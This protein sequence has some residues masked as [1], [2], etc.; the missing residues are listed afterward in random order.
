MVNFILG[1]LMQ[2]LTYHIQFPWVTFRRQQLRF[3]KRM[4]FDKHQTGTKHPALIYCDSYNW[5]NR[6]IFITQKSFAYFTSIFLELNQLSFGRLFFV[7]IL[8]VN[9]RCVTVFF[10]CVCT[11]VGLHVKFGE[12]KWVKV[13]YVAKEAWFS[14]ACETSL[15]IYD[16]YPATYN[17]NAS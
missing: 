6:K 3:K 5:S 7:V 16:F 17:L 8:L 11:K 14:W 12:M 10:S 2:W 9:F 13:A 4:D 1:V 15:S